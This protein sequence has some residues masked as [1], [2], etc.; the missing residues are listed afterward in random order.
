MTEFDVWEWTTMF[1][2]LPEAVQTATAFAAHRPFVRHVGRVRFDPYEDGA[3]FRL[4]DM[5]E[6]SYARSLQPWRDIGW[7]ASN[8]M[9]PTHALIPSAKP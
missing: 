8:G 5:L 7:I 3:S 6:W 4:A 9:R 1:C 2:D